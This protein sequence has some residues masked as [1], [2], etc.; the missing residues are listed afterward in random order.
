MRPRPEDDVPSSEDGP[1]VYEALSHHLLQLLDPFRVPDTK[2][3][4]L[5]W[6][7][8]LTAE[9]LHALVA[10]PRWAVVRALLSNA[11][12]RWLARADEEEPESWQSADPASEDPRPVEGAE[13]ALDE[14][15]SVHTRPPAAIIALHVGD[16]RE[17]L[18][19]DYAKAPFVSPLPADHARNR[20][21]PMA[22]DAQDGSAYG[23]LFATASGRPCRPRAHERYARALPWGLTNHAT[24]LLDLAARFPGRPEVWQ[25]YLAECLAHRVERAVPTRL[26]QAALALCRDRPASQAFV[27]RVALTAETVIAAAP[28]LE[29]LPV[30]GLL[31]VVIGVRGAI[32]RVIRD[33]EVMEPRLV[34]L[35]ELLGVVRLFRQ[36]SAIDLRVAWAEGRRDPN[37]ALA[38]MRER[39]QTGSLVFEHVLTMAL[40]QPS[41]ERLLA[42]AGDAGAR[43]LAY[44]RRRY[45][46]LRA[47]GQLGILE[48]GERTR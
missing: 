39:S 25:R 11:D 6:L 38:V 21:C 41:H 26:A 27:D 48:P 7:T 28:P 47:T 37:T 5:G 23:G 31:D 42:V 8:S 17:L 40:Q 32:A 4:A 10:D 43:A 24:W 16:L 14:S 9:D 1:S 29:L 2:R 36:A 34:A 12:D 18:M 45:E 20:A 46:V 22:C 13:P 3:P 33:A 15:P 44:T 30:E 19:D 35:A